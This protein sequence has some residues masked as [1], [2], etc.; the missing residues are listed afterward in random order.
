MNTGT[1][2]HINVCM[3]RGCVEGEDGP[4]RGFRA[5]PSRRC[6]SYHYLQGKFCP[7]LF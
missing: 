5:R 7:H 3:C 6:Q 4:D 2:T 1:C